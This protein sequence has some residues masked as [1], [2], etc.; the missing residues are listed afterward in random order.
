MEKEFKW[1]EAKI[2]EPMMVSNL[3]VLYVKEPHYQRK[4]PQNWK[5]R[6][7]YWFH[8]E[9]TTTYTYDVAITCNLT[10]CRVRPNDGI[11][12]KEG[13]NIDRTVYM[14]TKVF[15]QSG[16]VHCLIADINKAP[17]IYPQKYTEAAFMFSAFMEGK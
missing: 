4:L 5:E 16:T 7:K 17:E 13:Q 6:I 11:R 1:H 8:P 9:F 12:F 10:N 2:P 14:V 15:P 3:Q